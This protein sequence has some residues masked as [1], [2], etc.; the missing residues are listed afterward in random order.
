MNQPPDDSYDFAALLEQS[1]EELE[2]VSRGD[3]LEGTILAIDEQGMIIDVGLKRDG[4]IPRA[5]AEELLLDRPYRIGDRIIVMVLDPEDREGNLIVSI[6]HARAVKDWEAARC[7]M[8]QDGVYRA[9][10]LAANKGGLIV[11][12]G[13]LRGF[14][15]A[16]HVADMPRGL[17]DE[18]R[19]AYLSGYVGQVLNLKIVEVNARR[20]RLVFSQRLA[21]RDRRERAKEEILKNLHEGDVVRGRVRSLRDFGAF[22]DLGGADGLVHISELAWRR[23]RNPAEI[24]EIGQEVDVYV[25]QVDNEGKRIGLSL[26]RLQENPWA[27]IE[28]NYTIGQQVE[29]VVSRI[30]SYG[31]FVEL[32]NGIEALLH[33]SEMGDP[34]PAAPEELYVVGDPVT[35]YIISLEP[36]RQRMGLSLH[37]PRG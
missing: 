18:A 4:V 33:I 36:A 35:A 20:R 19:I 29:G 3:V 10:V 9:E 26:K 14:V 2:E 30:V 11:P 12:F 37:A 5:E 7:L 13:E 27:E 21:Q 8:D 22:I 16:S 25:L 23:V 6:K 31:V 1:F 28:A 17:D 32:F 24:L 15:P 34:P